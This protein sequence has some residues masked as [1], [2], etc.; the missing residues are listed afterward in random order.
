MSTEGEAIITA[1][2]EEAEVLG[3]SFDSADPG[4]AGKNAASAPKQKQADALIELAAAATLFHS[5]DGLGFADVEINGH[6][7]TW[8]IRS[9]GFRR[10]LTHRYFEARGGAPNSEALQSA[11]NLVEARAQ[12]DAPQREVHVRVGGL[13]GRLYLDLGDE[14]WRAVEIDTTGWRVID[15]PPV[16]FRRAAGVQALPIPE[17]GGSI[18][19]LRS[20]LNVQRDEDFVLVVAWVLAAL[21]PCGPYPVLGVSGEQGSAKSTFCT[22]VR[23][24]VDPN[25]AP[26]RALP[27]EDRASSSRPPTAT[28][29]RSTTFPPCRRGPPTPSA[30]LPPAGASR[31]A[32]STPTKTRCSLMPPGR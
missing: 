4:A 24:L 13:D 18:K 11:L 16:R 29:S 12:F 30:G 23:A 32:R 6:R 3:D 21:R 10:W 22:I 14:V 31:F 8:P 28:C 9:K 19:T 7:E 2:V 20:F 15:K 27:R 26:L 25:T 17:R 1:L 5:P